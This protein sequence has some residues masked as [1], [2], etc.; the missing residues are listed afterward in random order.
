M[1]LLK[2]LLLALAALASPH[3]G[4]TFHLWAMNE[5]F[6]NADGS[7]QFLEMTAI[8][9]S[10]QFLA[11]HVLEARCGGASRFF[12]FP[13]NLPGD[14]GGRRMLIATQGFAALNVVTPDYTVPNGFF[15]QGG[16]TIDF[17]HGADTWNHGATPSGGNSL[18]R[19][20]GTE[21]NSPTNFAGQSGSVSAGAPAV[22]ITP[23]E[24]D[25][26]SLAIGAT[27]GERS[28]T[29]ASNG[30]AAY[31]ITGLNSSSGCGNEP[32]CGGTD[33]ICTASCNVGADIAPGSSCQ[34]QAF[35]RPTAA[36]LRTANINVCDNIGG[37]R[38]ITIPLR[39]TGTSSPTSPPAPSMQGLWWRSPAGSENGWGVNITHQGDIIFA[40]WF[41]YDTDG[42]GMWLVMSEGRRP[43]SGSGTFTGAIYRTTGPAFNA[44]PWGSVTVTQVGT[45]TFTWDGV[46]NATFQYTVNGVTQTKA[47][48]R[49]VFSTPVPTCTL[50]TEGTSSSTFFQDLWWRSPANSE[51][52]WGVNITHQGDILFVTWFTY[53]STGRGMWLVMSDA[54]RTTGNTFA[55]DIFRTTGPVFSTATWNN[56]AVGVTSVGTGT[57]A[58][59]DMSNGTFSYTVNGVSQTKPIT[60]QVFS[61][62]ATICR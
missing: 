15:C 44:S 19:N 49:Q 37:G 2:S 62:P 31:R 34:V 47:I 42:T 20:G 1:R 4:A 59:T 39:G 13:A 40:T 30:S 25:F 33:F 38:S 32:L 35:F 21:P 28:I 24:V 58:F 48:T 36:G 43:N 57:L 10:Q 22:T 56:S 8:T 11:G 17:A 9:G 46:N 26:G 14:S 29:L 23:T 55:G 51:P 41:T 50:D 3:A 16:G 7:V 45:G 60:R 54:R 61:S 5:L 6:S 18:T 27:S 52:G 53:D 12:T